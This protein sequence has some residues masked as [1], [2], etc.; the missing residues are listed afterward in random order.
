MIQSTASAASS[1]TTTTTAVKHEDNST[2]TTTTNPLVKH[3]RSCTHVLHRAILAFVVGISLR[4]ARYPKRCIAVVSIISLAMMGIG[5]ATNFELALDDERIFA[6]DGCRPREHFS[7]IDS[8]AGYPTPH[9]PLLLVVHA[10]GD[11]V[12]GYEGMRR[13]FEATTLVRQLETY[14]HVCGSSSINNEQE[15]CRILGPTRYW[16]HNQTLFD[17]E[18]QGSDD[19]V[20]DMLSQDTFAGGVPAAHSYFLGNLERATQFNFDVTSDN[21]TATTTQGGKITYAESYLTGF[22]LPN[23]EASENPFGLATMDFETMA[24]EALLDLREEWANEE[25][26]QPFR[27]EVYTPRSVP[28]EMTRA[29]ASDL[30][31]LPLVFTIMALFTCLV[32]FRRD[33]VQSRALLGIGSVVTI[34]C[35]IMTGFGFS[36]ILGLPF[37]NL[38]Q[39]LPFVIFGT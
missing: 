21:L 19:T 17:E 4:A 6:P 8:V 24:L 12:L 35:S 2:A 22:E 27:L 13:M 16:Y 37:T 7:F 36:F 10:H 31:L 20:Q 30:P 1:T 26:A 39:V 25:P 28:D 38:T 11:N 9:R 5:L 34:V 33:Q 29:V 3:W 32:F 23:L 15:D 18:T 14:P